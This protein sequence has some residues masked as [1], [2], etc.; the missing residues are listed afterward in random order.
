MA[1][2]V[3]NSTMGAAAEATALLDA[4][5]SGELGVSFGIAGELIM[6]CREAAESLNV[7]Q[8]GP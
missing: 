8:G 2:A 6:A 5:D 1:L 4:F 3:V 7:L